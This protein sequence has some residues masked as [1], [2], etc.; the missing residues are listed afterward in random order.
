[1]FK[2]AFVI[3]VLLFSS[4]FLVAQSSVGLSLQ[5]GGF[6]PIGN[7]SNIYE[8]GLGG[9]ATLYFNVDKNFEVGISGG[10]IKYNFNTSGLNKEASDQ[11]GTAITIKI[12]APLTI[13][14][15]MLSGRYIFESSRLKPYIIGELGAHYVSMDF[16][17]FNIGNEL[18]DLN[19]TA[20]DIVVGF[21]AGVG[22]LFKLDKGVYIDINGKINGNT[23][24]VNEF[25]SSDSGD[26]F[27]ER[28][29]TWLSVMAGIHF[30]L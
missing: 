5:A 15:L 1:M 3:S 10:Y 18:I 28:T 11:L 14:P 19:E 27:T 24:S 30:E 8:A 7:F 17:S 16:P 23:L 9:T 20:S 25:Q 13:I 2:K 6:F 12:D 26:N 21:G 29:A 22:F 4:N